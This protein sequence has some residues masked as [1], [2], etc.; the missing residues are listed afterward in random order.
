[1]NT[2]H[3]TEA[4]ALSIVEQAD[5]YL[6]QSGEALAL[7]WESAVDDAL[8]SLLQMPERGASCHLKAPQL[9]GIRWILLAGFPKYMVFYRY[10]ADES[11]VHSLHLLHG[12]QDIE[13]IFGP[14]REKG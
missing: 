9:V 13:F 7:R 12:A 11:I 1:M 10:A 8:R 4:A 6:Q 2:L 14:E 3:L 5:Y